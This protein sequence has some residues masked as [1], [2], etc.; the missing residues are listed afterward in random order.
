MMMVT[1]RKRADYSLMDCSSC[2]QN[3]TDTPGLFRGIAEV[4]DTDIIDISDN[5]CTSGFLKQKKGNSLPRIIPEIDDLVRN[6]RTWIQHCEES[7]R[8]DQPVSFEYTQ[9]F[10]DDEHFFS[11][12]VRYLCISV[13]GNPRFAYVISDVTE[14]RRMERQFTLIRKKLDLMNI[15]AW[16]EIQNKI[17]GIRGYVDLSRDLT[18][19]EKGMAFIEAEERLLGQIHDLLQYTMDYQKI[20]SL[21]R[22]WMSVEDAVHQAWSRIGVTLLRIDLDL[23]H[24]ELFCDPTLDRMFSL[25]IE[26]TLKNQSTN[27]EVRITC[28]E[29]PDGLCLTYEDNSAGLSGSRKRD[30]FTR[31]IVRAQDFCITFVHDILESSGMSIRETGEPGRGT[32]FEI[33]VPQGLFRFIEGL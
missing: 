11:A 16:H 25:L 14:R 28:T 9:W 18:Q 13:S 29:V 32:R 15:V 17:S 4:V 26:Y 10:D 5:P 21:P 20:G 27:P 1:D 33:T 8:L 19:D 6:N 12:T 22:R 31:E 24:L 23:D 7:R 2:I 30:L 3:I